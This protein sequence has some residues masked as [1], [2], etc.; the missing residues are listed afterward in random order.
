MR[1]SERG[2][3]LIIATIVVLIIAVIS[4]GMVRFTQRETAGALAWQRAD[5]TAACAAAAQNL[6]LSRFHVLGV[7]PS[8]LAVLN[9]K[10]DGTTGRMVALGGHIGAD[11][12]QPIAT[13]KQVEALP[14]VTVVKK[15][16][17]S[18]ETNYVSTTSGEGGQPFKVTVH[19][20]EG[21]TSTPTSGRQ[22]EIEYGVNFGL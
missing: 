14:A 2:S 6:L 15:N 18:D 10:L 12:T 21:D 11:P 7:Q 8:D 3:A 5:A 9:V 4:V 13:I 1:K 19:C 16:T 17:M 22:V 20:Q